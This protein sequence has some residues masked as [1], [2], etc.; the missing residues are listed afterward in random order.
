MTVYRLHIQDFYLFHKVQPSVM[1]TQLAAQLVL[2]L[3]SLKYE[4][5]TMN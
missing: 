3:F 5:E 1:S 4:N 2:G